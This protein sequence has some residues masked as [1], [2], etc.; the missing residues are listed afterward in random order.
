[1]AREPLLSQVEIKYRSNNL[2]TVVRNALEYPTNLQLIED[3][4]PSDDDNGCFQYTFSNS[5]WMDIS[6]CS[7]GLSDSCFVGGE[8]ELQICYD[9]ELNTLVV[10]IE[11][12]VLYHD[13]DFGVCIIDS[14]HFDTQHADSWRCESDVFY[15]HFKNQIMQEVNFLVNNNITSCDNI[16]SVRLLSRYVRKQC[17]T[18]CVTRKG[19]FE[20]ASSL[21]C[22]SNSACC[23]L[24]EEWC[25]G[26][27]DELIVSLV[28]NY[29]LGSCDTVEDHP[30]PEG[31]ELGVV[32]SCS[33]TNCLGDF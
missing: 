4:S 23:V 32:Y 12:S 28:E 17:F 20:I 19:G 18:Y 33:V 2:E 7:E 8:M 1:M 14:I 27:D 10:N 16:N 21:D 15:N 30:C 26:K 25:F 29:A 22:G 13:M 6:N 24:V 11:E 31:E 5:A 9:F 3:C